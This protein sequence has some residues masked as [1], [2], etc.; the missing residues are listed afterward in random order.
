MLLSVC[1]C[2]NPVGE[3]RWN[4]PKKLVSNKNIHVTKNT[5]GSM[6]NSSWKL[7]VP[8][9]FFI[10]GAAPEDHA[11]TKRPVYECLTLQMFR[12][13]KENKKKKKVKFGDI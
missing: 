10:L 12:V 1:V 4:E 8:F 13:E 3:I 6:L 2:R 9:S 7:L 11:Q 5:A